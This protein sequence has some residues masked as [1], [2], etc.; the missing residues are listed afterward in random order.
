MSAILN[1]AL[2]ADRGLVEQALRDAIPRVGPGHHYDMVADY[3]RRGGKRIRPVLCMAASRLYGGTPADA[4]PAAVALELFHNA[5]LVHDD[6]E[7]C[8][9]RRRGR[10]T[11]HEAF[12]TACAINIGDALSALAL[13]SLAKGGRHWPADV[14]GAVIVEF[15]H[16]LQRTT[17]G[18]ATELAWIAEDCYDL[19]DDD[20]LALI[21]DKTCW[22]TTTHPLR[23]GALIGSRG[24]ADVN[25]LNDLGFYLGAVFQIHDD[26]ENLEAGPA[27]GKDAQGDILEGKRTLPLLHLLRAAGPADRALARRMTGPHGEGSPE[28][29]TATVSALMERYGSLDYARRFADALS[30]LALVEFHRLFRDSPASEAVQY[31]FDLVMDLRDGTQPSSGRSRPRA[32]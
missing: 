29:R 22:Y 3:P 1:R 13:V 2:A 32:W 8:S 23:I 9:T 25:R 27:Y 12:G 6:I 14:A 30:G 4:L 5:F 28:E 15:A 21:R 19:S 11:L 26:I 17:E 20:Y 10:P 31:L 7:D 16:L 18:Q 24:R